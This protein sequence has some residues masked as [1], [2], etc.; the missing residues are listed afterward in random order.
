MAGFFA[1]GSSR[2]GCGRKST[3]GRKANIPSRWDNKRRKSGHTITKEEYTKMSE[4]MRTIQI[5]D[6]TLRDGEQAPGASLQ[7][8]QKIVL[9]GKLAELALT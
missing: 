7:P 4:S 3:C 6:T 2:V 9:A 8:E 1:A 5:F